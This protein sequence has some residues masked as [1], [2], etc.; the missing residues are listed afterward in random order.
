MVVNK[1][2]D[3]PVDSGLLAG[4]MRLRVLAGGCACCQT[5]PALVKL[6]RDIC[7]DRVGGD[8]STPR[9]DRIVLE[10]SGLADPARIAES[11]VTDPV[12]QH[13][14]VVGE[15]IVMVDAVHGLGHMRDEEL[16]RRQIETADMLVVTKVDAAEREPLR[17][18]IAT[19]RA[20]NPGATLSGSVMGSP[21]TCR[22]PPASS[23]RICRP[24]TRTQGRGS[25]PP[26]WRSAKRSTGRRFRFG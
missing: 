16:G 23:R 18:L 2:A 6:L 9:I 21:A 25:R 3:T 8:A 17:R 20:L 10:T 15:I 7:D 13:H 4:S 26:H 5:R 14:I 12:L 11:I 19:L 24:Q 1:A 22:T